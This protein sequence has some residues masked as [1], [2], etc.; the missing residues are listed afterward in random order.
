MFKFC[1]TA[2]FFSCS[3]TLTTETTEY[4]QIYF[5]KMD[6]K[7]KVGEKMRKQDFLQIVSVMNQAGKNLIRAQ[8]EEIKTIE[9]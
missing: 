3:R 6:W 8:R 9:I 2:G 5:S 1:H 4:I 7:I